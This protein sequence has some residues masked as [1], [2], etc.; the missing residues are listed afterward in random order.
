MGDY[1]AELFLADLARGRRSLARRPR[2][3]FLDRHFNFACGFLHAAFACGLQLAVEV[4]AYDFASMQDCTVISPKRASRHL[5]S[6]GTQF[7]RFI[8]S[9]KQCYNRESEKIP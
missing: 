8:D 6:R 7:H 9:T 3:S 4:S 1:L 2:V 5:L